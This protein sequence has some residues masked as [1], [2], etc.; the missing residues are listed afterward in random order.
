MRVRVAFVNDSVVEIE[1]EGSYDDLDDLADALRSGSGTIACDAGGDPAP[2]AAALA[3]LI[4]ESTD[5]DRV[6]FH[7]DDTGVRIVGGAAPC[8]ELAELVEDLADGA[9][10]THVHVEWAPEHPLIGKGSIPAVLAL[11][12]PSGSSVDP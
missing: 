10:G 7:A 3:S 6:R 2:Y 9:Y 12:R 1:I 5:D 4:V 8:E 11:P